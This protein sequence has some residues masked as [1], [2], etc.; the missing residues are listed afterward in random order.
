[1][2]QTVYELLKKRIYLLN[3]D[4][5]LSC[6]NIKQRRDLYGYRGI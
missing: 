5:M 2:S 3:T 1:M 6:D 4:L